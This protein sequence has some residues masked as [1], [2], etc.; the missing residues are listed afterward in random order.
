[1]SNETVQLD[2]EAVPVVLY[3]ASDV[4]SIAMNAMSIQSG[5]RDFVESGVKAG[6]YAVDNP[7]FVAESALLDTWQQGCVEWRDFIYRVALEVTR[8]ERLLDEV[9]HELD[10]GWDGTFEYEVSEEVGAVLAECVMTGGHMRSNG[11][12]HNAGLAGLVRYTL[13]F[14]NKYD[15]E[16]QFRVAVGLQELFGMDIWQAVGQKQGE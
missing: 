10:D 16:V 13:I 5:A 3:S 8:V 7:R 1:M 15:A 12:L 14:V 9:F 6:T 4:H 11:D 2:F